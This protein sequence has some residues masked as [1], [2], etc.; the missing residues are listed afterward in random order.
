MGAKLEKYAG[1]PDGKCRELDPKLVEKIN[2][3]LDLV[4][5]NKR[6]DFIGYIFTVFDKLTEKARRY[7]EAHNE[8][9]GSVLRKIIDE[10]KEFVEKL[11]YF[12]KSE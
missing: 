1:T 8:D 12:R 6:T 11:S 10:D 5:E 3:T 2:R 7:A 4:D 9:Y